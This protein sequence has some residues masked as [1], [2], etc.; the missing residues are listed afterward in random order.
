M[1][2]SLAS[3]IPIG[4]FRAPGTPSASLAAWSSALAL[5]TSAVALSACGGRADGPD[6]AGPGGAYS[7]SGPGAHSGSSQGS[8]A[9]SCGSADCSSYS[10][11]CSQGTPTNVRCVLDVNPQFASPVC[12]LAGDCVPGAAPTCSWTPPPPPSSCGSGSGSSGSGAGS[13]S[14]VCSVAAPVL[15]GPVVGV[16]SL[17]LDPAA[18][19]AGASVLQAYFNYASGEVTRTLGDCVYDPKGADQPQMDTSGAPAPNEGIITV[20]AAPGFKASIRPA[21]DGTYAPETSAGAI[22]PGTVVSFAFS[23][24][25][26][27]ANPTFSVPGEDFPTELP[28]IPAPHLVALGAPCALAA[29]SPSVPRASDLPVEWTVTGTPLALERVVVRV[30]QRAATVTCAFDAG[31]GSGVVP[32]DALLKLGA[33][34]ATYGVYSVHEADEA[35]SDSGGA[36]VRYEVERA[37]ATPAGLAKGT[38]ALE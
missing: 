16:V 36:V 12:V 10:F 4:H 15:L 1:K 27:F 11:S 5:A 35:T 32:A 2:P 23:P 22:D 31:A 18:P 38:L 17:E 7:G 9:T 24:A 3:T 14:A 20:T 21:C 25:A 34:D 30:T 13:S 19:S 37:A 33:G 6:A 26:A 8:G 29:V 28:S